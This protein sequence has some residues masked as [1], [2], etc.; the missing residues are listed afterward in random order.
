MRKVNPIWVVVLGLVA[1]ACGGEPALDGRTFKTTEITGDGSPTGV[2]VSIEFSNG[3][4]GVGGGCNRIGGTYELEGNFL[5]VSDL[6][7][8]EMACEQFL[9]NIDTAIINLLGQ[10]LR[11]EL[12]DNRLRLID[13]T[14]GVVDWFGDREADPEYAVSGKT[15]SIDGV[16]RNGVVGS[17]AD[18]AAF[19]RIEDGTVHVNTGCNLGS[20][21]VKLSG[22]RATFGPIATTR[23]MCDP[24]TMTLE[25]AV[26]E[27]LSGEAVFEI[28]EERATLAGGE[29]KLHLVAKEGE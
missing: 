18:G 20:G 29:V 1:A 25:K 11:V 27:V 5:T 26:L 12:G 16:E 3:R 21:S 6:F 15:W 22:E 23:K 4:V 19:I 7:M 24:E 8:T 28:S 14:G 13:E 17:V 10:E 2:E 9:M